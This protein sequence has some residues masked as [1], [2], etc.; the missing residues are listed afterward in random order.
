MRVRVGAEGTWYD[1]E[2]DR[3]LVRE[4]R[5]L[6]DLTGM[7]LQD[8]SDGIRHGKV[9]ALVFMLYLARRRAG[10]AVRFREF[11]EM[12]LA[13]LEI[14]GDEDETPQQEQAEESDV[15]PLAGG[16][17]GTNAV[18]L[19]PPTELRPATE[20]KPRKARKKVATG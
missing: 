13:E 15:S 17:N 6:Q 10:E 7:G 5:E 4:A 18:A 2:G 14:Q 16:G 8:F 12:N 3:L 11:D 1:F 20:P 19:P 9:D